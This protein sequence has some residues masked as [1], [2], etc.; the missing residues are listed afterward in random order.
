MTG[1]E[2]AMDSLMKRLRFWRGALL[3]LVAGVAVL[4]WGEWAV[5]WGRSRASAMLAKA[6][7]PDRYMPEDMFQDLSTGVG[8]WVW[9]ALGAK[10]IPFGFFHLFKKE[11]LSKPS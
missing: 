4:G 8:N 10:S 3:Y 6:T 11:Q 7:A 9:I 1:N 2:M 5:M